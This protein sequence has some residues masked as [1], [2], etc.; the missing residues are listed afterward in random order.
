MNSPPELFPVEPERASWKVVIGGM[1]GLEMK[2]FSRKVL[3]SDAAVAGK[4][5]LMAEREGGP[6]PKRPLSPLCVAFDPGAE[7]KKGEIQS[8]VPIYHRN[9]E[10]AA[11]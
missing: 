5:F 2:T 11:Y 1:V 7:T 9:F 4:R 8:S 3:A 10:I 6:T